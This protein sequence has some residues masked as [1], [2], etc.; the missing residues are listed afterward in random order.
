MIEQERGEDELGT[1]GEKGMT[2]VP[3]STFAADG[4]LSL[5]VRPFLPLVQRSQQHN[6]VVIPRSRGKATVVVAVVCRGKLHRMSGAVGMMAV[7]C[8]KI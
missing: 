6:T 1:C 2:T 7:P 3:T 8:W 4:T 5:H